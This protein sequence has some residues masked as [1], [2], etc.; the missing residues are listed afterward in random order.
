MPNNVVV[1]KYRQKIII[2]L[3]Y[4]MTI[5]F[6]VIILQN[7]LH[8]EKISSN[9]L[10]R[11][12]YTLLFLIMAFGSFYYFNYTF[13]KKVIFS[14]IGLALK[15]FL[16]KE[17]VYRWNMISK[18]D[19]RI[20]GFSSSEIGLLQSQSLWLLIR[21]IRKV[22]KWMVQFNIGTE[23]KHITLYHIP[24]D[25]IN[26]IN[27]CIYKNSKLKYLSYKDLKNPKRREVLWSW[28]L[29]G[30]EEEKEET[31][32]LVREIPPAMFKE[33]NK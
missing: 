33:Y 12:F 21:N 17:K 30:T 3:S 31:E 1:L 11:I 27:P 5:P 7:N 26:E 9:S 14:P 28:N 23:Q 24:F 8:P 16:Q 32:R 6:F 22:G 20:K 10:E 29:A 4:L 18:V 19:F 2:I 13:K 25:F 15:L